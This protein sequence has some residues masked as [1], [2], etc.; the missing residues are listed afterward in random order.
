L[1]TPQNGTYFFKLHV[2]GRNCR[3]P[4]DTERA[5]VLCQSCQKDKH[6]A[7]LSISPWVPA[8]R[9]LRPPAEEEE[10]ERI[11]LDMC[12]RLGLNI[13]GLEQQIRSGSAAHL[14]EVPATETPWSISGKAARIQKGEDSGRII[15]TTHRSLPHSETRSGGKKGER[16]EVVDSSLDPSHTDHDEEPEWEDPDAADAEVYYDEQEEEEESPFDE[17]TAGPSLPKK[18]K[19][20]Q[21]KPKRKLTKKP[22]GSTKR[23]VGEVDT[24]QKAKKS[25]PT[26][27]HVDLPK[28][29]RKS[30]HQDEEENE[31]P[32]KKSKKGNK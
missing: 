12:V 26:R 9:R 32:K 10:L 21:T 20:S 16:A 24:K 11:A 27:G 13:R 5:R 22:K 31:K 30:R 23:A 28:K 1:A 3:N 15:G 6:Y 18:A 29:S 2:D 14:L 17:T 8:S 25:K 19:T 4:D 7:S